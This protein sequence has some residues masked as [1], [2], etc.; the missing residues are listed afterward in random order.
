MIMVRLLIGVLL[1]TAIPVTAFGADDDLTCQ[2]VCRD[3]PKKVAGGQVTDQDGKLLARH[4]YG[5]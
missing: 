5:K 4:A 2:A 3:Y 1:M